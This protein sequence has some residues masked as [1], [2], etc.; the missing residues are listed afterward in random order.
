MTAGVDSN[1]YLRLAAEHEALMQFLY[2][3]PVG[4]VQTA[5]DGTIVMINPVSAQLLM[6]LQRDGDLTNLFDALSGVAPGLRD[7]CAAYA[8]ARGMVCDGLRI[9]LGGPDARATRLTLLK[10]DDA[11]LMAVLADVTAH[12]DGAPSTHDTRAATP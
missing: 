2:L 12:A 9:H 3:A 7:L 10:L 5:A 4:L 8:P 6:P 11:R 1:A